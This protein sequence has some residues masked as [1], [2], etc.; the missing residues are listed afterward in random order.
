MN[1]HVWHF[2]VN[3]VRE[4]LSPG[5]LLIPTCLFVGALLYAVLSPFL[6]LQ[7]TSFAVWLGPPDSDI[8]HHFS[9]SLASFA[10]RRSPSAITRVTL[11]GLLHF[12]WFS[13]RASARTLLRG[14]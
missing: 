9:F 12:V 8:A 2:E 13:G 14:I 5:A 7:M 1:K 4:A 10:A 11:S 3:F 6:R